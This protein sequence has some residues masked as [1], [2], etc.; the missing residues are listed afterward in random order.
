MWLKTV[1]WEIVSETANFYAS[2]IV[3]DN[4]TKQFTFKNVICPDEKAGIQNDN[5][6]TNAIARETMTFAAL[7]AR[8]FNFTANSLWDRYSENMLIL[9]PIQLPGSGKKL[10]HPEYAGYGKCNIFIRSSQSLLIFDFNFTISL[11]K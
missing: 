6:F 8:K 9:K 5:P 11:N 2:R 1:G 10:I 3:Q 7:I 4:A